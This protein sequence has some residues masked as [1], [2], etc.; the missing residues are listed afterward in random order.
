MGNWLTISKTALFYIWLD[1][2]IVKKCVFSFIVEIPI[3]RRLQTCIRNEPCTV[4]WQANM[5]ASEL[6]EADGF[7]LKRSTLEMCCEYCLIALHW[8]L[9]WS[10][11]EQRLGEQRSGEQESDI[12]EKP[13]TG[14]GATCT[15]S[16]L[17]EIICA[18]LEQSI[19]SCS[20]GIYIII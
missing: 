12:F 10:S 8:E 4:L 13:S 16:H 18:F 19:E 20:Q 1:H 5:E 6:K 17:Q 15:L 7:I 2:F 11:G 14:F 3:R 9:R